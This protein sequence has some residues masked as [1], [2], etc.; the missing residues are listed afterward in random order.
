MKRI[1]LG[2]ISVIVAVLAFAAIG[3]GNVSLDVDD[4]KL[5]QREEEVKLI[6]VNEGGL[7]EERDIKKE[8]K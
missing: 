6:D 8:E 2:A 3:S 4:N 5:E 7:P 1:I